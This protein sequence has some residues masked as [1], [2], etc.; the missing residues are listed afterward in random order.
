MKN[1]FWNSETKH[2]KF[3]L[4]KNERLYI[5]SFNSQNDLTVE[6]CGTGAVF[7]YRSLCIFGE[8]QRV[9]QKIYVAHKA[10]NTKSFLFARHILSDN[11]R[12]VFNGIVEVEKHSAN[13]SSR[14][15]VNSILLSP[16]AKAVSKPELKICCDDVECRH[17]STC[18]GLDDN[19]L[20]YLQSR[21]M[22]PEA[23]KKIL[24]YAFAAEI[25]KE[26]P[27]EEQRKCFSKQLQ[28]F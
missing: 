26:H 8:E 20:F 3:S 22:E 15:L 23:A 1:L 11:S 10:Q 7:E 9:E 5:L 2:E 14:Q 18:G 12:A 28:I 24:Q 4:A 17:G 13:I 6:L 27:S 19:S 25:A 21:G 16:G